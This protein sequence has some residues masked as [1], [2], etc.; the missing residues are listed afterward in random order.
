MTLFVCNCSASR[1]HV[2]LVGVS[3]HLCIYVQTKKDKWLKFAIIFIT[4][5]EIDFKEKL[6]FLVLLFAPDLKKGFI[7]ALHP[8]FVPQ[9]C[10]SFSRS[11]HY[12]DADT[13]S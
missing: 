10:F 7:K 5:V 4:R 1:M 8:L 12:I 3:K 11:L 9:L 2:W 6:I 13:S